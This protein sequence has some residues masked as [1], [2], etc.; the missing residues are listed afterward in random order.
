[1]QNQDT[2]KEAFKEHCAVRAREN[3]G[4]ALSFSAMPDGA[5]N[6]LYWEIAMCLF[7]PQ[8]LDE[9]FAV[10]LPEITDVILIVTPDNPSPEAKSPST[11][12][13]EPV[14]KKEALS[15]SETGKQAC[16]VHTIKNCMITKDTLL[17]LDNI[18]TLSFAMHQQLFLWL[19]E[20]SPEMAIRLYTH[21]V[22][23]QNLE[24]RSLSIANN[25]QT[26]R[27]AIT[28]LMNGLNPREPLR[29]EFNRANL[30]ITA[31]ACYLQN[32]PEYF[33]SGVLAL[34]WL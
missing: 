34:Q 32:L 8:N 21:Q 28:R 31:F 27:K 24:Q 15:T 14:I 30:A 23:V 18:N 26:A 4:G 13:P 10:L 6:K 25:Q 29:Y 3:H 33:L 17:L 16:P 20:H 19:K 9:M 1:M 22:V 12:P 5:T 11:P 7:K 2:C